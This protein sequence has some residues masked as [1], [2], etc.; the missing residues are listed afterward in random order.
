MATKIC[1]KCS[2][3]ALKCGLCKDCFNTRAREKYA[4][5]TPEQKERR[6]E[7]HRV[8]ARKRY[9]SCSKEMYKE[10]Y[11]KN[12]D[13]ILAYARKANKKWRANNKEKFYEMVKDWNK[14]FPEKR[15]EYNRQYQIRL[16]LKKLEEKSK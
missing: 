5:M 14:R 12:H 11:I 6:K 3:E 8:Y 15:A 10:N 4:N 7:Q 2:N 1:K 16:K 13:K 9:G